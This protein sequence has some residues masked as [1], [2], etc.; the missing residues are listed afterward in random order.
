MGKPTLP[1][2]HDAI[3]GIV[4]VDWQA[5]TASFRFLPVEPAAE[6]IL[7]ASGLRDLHI[8]RIEPWGPSVSVNVAEYVE[9]DRLDEVGLRVEMQSGDEIH[10]ASG[11]PETHLGVVSQTLRCFAPKPF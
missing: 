7:V 2:L 11:L 5:A 1:N 10:T 6:V 3:L 9:T 8:P 4:Q